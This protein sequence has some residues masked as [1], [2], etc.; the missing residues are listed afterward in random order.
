[1]LA[2]EQAV[3]LNPFNRAARLDLRFAR[4]TAQ[5]ESPDLTWYEVVSSWL[6]VNWW[7]WLAGLSLWSTVG[8]GLLPGIFRVRKA[9]WHQAVAACSMT[10]FLLCLPAL[11][12]VET[13]SRTG[14][15]LSKETPLR[16]T[17]T[18]EAQMITHLAAG[19]PVRVARS[20]GQYVLVRTHHTLGWIE[21]EQLGLLCR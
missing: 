1:M 6:P 20:R 10:V 4:R 13:R 5:L 11:V 14:F 16:L 17:P 18:A 19:D 7:T 21:R 8:L 9:A 12:G 2:W 15:I 3:W